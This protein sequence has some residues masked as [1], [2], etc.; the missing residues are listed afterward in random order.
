LRRRGR[1]RRRRR[2]RKRRRRNEALE[3]IGTAMTKKFGII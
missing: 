2:T 3:V 1:R